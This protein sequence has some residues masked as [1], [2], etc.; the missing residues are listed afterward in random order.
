MSLQ[1]AYMQARDDLTSAHHTNMHLPVATAQ[2]VDDDVQC[3]FDNL[4]GTQLG[5]RMVYIDN[6]QKHTDKTHTHLKDSD[7]EPSAI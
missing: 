6:T 5:K 2:V 1:T 3:D 4:A 7:G